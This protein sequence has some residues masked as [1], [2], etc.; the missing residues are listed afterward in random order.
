MDKLNDTKPRPGAE[1]FQQPQTATQRQYE[2]LRAYLLEGRNAQ[3]VGERFGYSPT[4]LYALARELRGGRLRFFEPSKP[5]PKKA[6]KREAAR[7][8]VIELRKQ[9]Y[10]I[11]DIQKILR[12]EDCP[13]SHV[14]IHQILREEGFAK[15]PRRRGDERPAV[16]R[17]EVAEVADVRQLDWKDFQN[18][19]TE[20]T[21][22]FVLL[23]QLI[24][25][26]LP[27]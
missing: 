11:Y 2:A 16:I 17:P 25:W 5:G 21:A 12:V 3:Q 14:L 9:N 26:G 27:R 19:E 22:L 8:R 6:P 15:L 7:P 24:E 20:G 23:P 13:L 1:F 18:F 10:S 4:T